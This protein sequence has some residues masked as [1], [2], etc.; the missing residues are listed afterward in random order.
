MSSPFKVSDFWDVAKPGSVLC[1]LDGR[2]TGGDSMILPP[3]SL[4][5]SSSGGRIVVRALNDG[6]VLIDGEGARE[7]VKLGAWFHLEGVNACCSRRSVVIANEDH[8]I[9]RRVVAWDA[10]DGNNNIFA[11]HGS[12][13]VVFEDVAG[14]GIARK[15]MSFSQN[16]N[17]GTLRRV[18]ARWEGSH[19]QG[20][21]LG[22]TMAYNNYGILL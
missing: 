20:P 15:V 5:G 19:T 2:Y 6:K 17:N 14:F 16:G 1:M 10:A 18:W 7:P 11:S 4:K 8:T 21:K 3:S 9:V 22:I 12:Q 13:F